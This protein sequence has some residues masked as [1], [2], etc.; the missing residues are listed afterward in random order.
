MENQEGR[1]EFKIAIMWEIICLYYFSS[2]LY[3]H[4]IQFLEGSSCMPSNYR[5]RLLLQKKRKNHKM[6]RNDYISTIKLDGLE[7]R[8]YNK[9]WEWVH[10]LIRLKSTMGVTFLGKTN[11]NSTLLHIMQ[12]VFAGS[13]RKKLAGNAGSFCRNLGCLNT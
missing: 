10:D 4:I 13:L 7:I 1:K 2:R 6:T 3:P 9:S 5:S 11:H 12:S 8:Q